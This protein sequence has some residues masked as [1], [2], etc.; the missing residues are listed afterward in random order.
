MKVSDVLREK[1]REVE[2]VTAAL[3]V[4]EAI[5]RFVDRRVRSFVVTDNGR[6]V[7]VISQKDILRRL[8]TNGADALAEE[9]R[10]VMTT[11]IVTTNPD[12]SIDEVEQ[13][14]LDKRL[15]HL[16]VLDGDEL[17]GIITPA[18]VFDSHLHDVQFFNDRLLHY[19][20][21]GG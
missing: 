2:T 21:S 8:H 4:T 11:D 17:I 10:Q 14:F 7:G 15:N 1:G 6:V 5:G 18:D 3:P 13:V 20:Y 9:V 12:A 19:I 16:P